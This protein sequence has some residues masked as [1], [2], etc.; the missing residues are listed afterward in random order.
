[1]EG[2]LR[3]GPP[4]VYHPVCFKTPWGYIGGPWRYQQATD[5]EEAK[6]LGPIIIPERDD[7]EVDLDQ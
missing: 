5:E 2:E 4:M 3:M 7:D 1:M 6:R